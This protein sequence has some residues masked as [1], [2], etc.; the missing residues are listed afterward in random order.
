MLGNSSQWGGGSYQSILRNCLLQT[1]F[2]NNLGGGA[3]GGT[4]INSTLTWNTA[5]FPGAG[6]GSRALIFNSI[7]YNNYPTNSP[8]QN[9]A[10]CDSLSL[11]QYSCTTPLP[12][13]TG[14]IGVDPQLLDSIHLTSTS[15]CR[16]AG[17][18]NYVSGVDIDGEPWATPPSMGCDEYIEA[19]ITGPLAV[20]AKPNW[21]VAVAGKGLFCFAQITG[22]AT[23]A[24]W[25]FGDGSELTNASVL[26]TYH[27]WTNPG[28]YTVSFTAF[29]ADNPTGVSTNF[30]LRV[31]PLVAPTLSVAGY[32][33][34]GLSLS[35]PGQFGVL[36]Y[37]EQATN[38]VPPIVWQT[39]TTRQGDGPL[40]ISSL[41]MTNQSG[42]F[43]IRTQ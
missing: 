32:S 7:I 15:P 14:N 26:I 40:V 17:S 1:N 12:S 10:N 9:S 2:A 3:Y 42:F 8:F 11:L 20:T 33:G 39:V 37:L 6:V 34:S 27:T 28:D 24:A 21:P 16:G 18:S 43:R 5:P 36:Y 35:F 29:N 38:L 23:R 41:P 31:D 30:A 25:S 19:G 22:R 4:I 13:G